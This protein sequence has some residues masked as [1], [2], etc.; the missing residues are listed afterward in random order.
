VRTKRQCPL[1]HQVSWVALKV[2]GGGKKEGRTAFKRG[3]GSLVSLV[4]GLRSVRPV[5]IQ[6]RMMEAEG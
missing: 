4:V 2:I 6:G 3:T 1:H 5:S